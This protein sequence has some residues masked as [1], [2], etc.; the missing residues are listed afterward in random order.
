MPDFRLLLLLLAVSGCADRPDP[1]TRA[2]AAADQ[3]GGIC[4]NEMAPILDV[5]G[6]MLENWDCEDRAMRGI[7]SLVF[8]DQ[9]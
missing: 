2:I 5:S 8:S 1:T 4:T 6:G 3:S 7:A 9:E